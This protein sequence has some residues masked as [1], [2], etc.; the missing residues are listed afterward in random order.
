MKT[1]YTKHYFSNNDD[2]NKANEG[3]AEKKWEN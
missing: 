2:D 3:E 1:F